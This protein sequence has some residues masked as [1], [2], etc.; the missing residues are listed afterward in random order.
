MIYRIIFILFFMTNLSGCNE[1]IHKDYSYENI[2]IDTGW[3]VLNAKLR[4]R[5]IKIGKKLSATGSPYELLIWF[6]CDDKNI[7]SNDCEI[8]LDKLSIFLP[9]TG[10]EVFTFSGVNSSFFNKKDN[11]YTASFIFNNIDL[12][13]VDYKLNL[14]Y[15]IS[16]KCQIDYRES[17]VSIFFHRD[18]QEKIIS[19]W[20][21]LM[22]I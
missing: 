3:G 13:Y 21:S 16:N 10:D 7:I 2:K 19:F 4:G 17:Q 5:P 22:G 20:D 14:T 18:Y 1:T 11:Q 12:K 15:G 6:S 8:F 9:E